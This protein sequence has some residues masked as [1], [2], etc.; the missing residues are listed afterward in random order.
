VGGRD[1]PD[2]STVGSRR[3][4]EELRSDLT[5]PDER[6]QPEWWSARV[7]HRDGTEVAG[8]RMGEG[9]YTLRVLDADGRMWSFRKRDLSEY[10]RVETSTMPS[11]ASSLSPTELEDLVAYLYGLTRRR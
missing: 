6:V 1:G 3:S 2:L 4:P 11:Y 7:T 5:D 9:T 10:E 8:R